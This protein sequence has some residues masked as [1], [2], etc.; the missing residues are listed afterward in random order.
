MKVSI[1]IPCHNEEDAI[2]ACLESCL[3]QTRAHDEI[4][5]VDDGSTD[6]TASILEGYR[7]R[8][9][10]ATI[11][12]A[13]GNKSY[14]QERGLHDVTGDIVVMTDGD[15]ILD[16][17]FVARVV[18]RFAD[19]NIAAVCGYVK[20]I[21]H[22]WLTACREIEYI[23]AQEITKRLQASRHAITVIPGCAAVFRTAIFRRH[24]GFDHD[25]LTEDRDFT[26]KLHEARLQILYA[27]DAI[28]HTQDP[29]TLGAYV[30]QVRRWYGGS[31]QNLFKHRAMLM[32]AGNAAR[33]LSGYVIMLCAALSL[34]IMP[35]FSVRASI[36][37]ALSLC[38]QT[39]PVSLYAY[40]VRGRLDLIKYTPF[41]L[42]TLL[43]RAW[44]FVEQ[45]VYQ[46]ILRKKDLVWHKPPRR[47]VRYPMR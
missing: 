19:E 13:T 36:Y 45:F 7:G 5:V 11:A 20:S 9:K 6:R 17:N 37:L 27:R 24:V 10:I 21:D 12:N 2:Q 41:S 18:P 25:T 33:F 35:I 26:F 31:W 39:L 46:I 14:A 29:A 40:L 23:I 43:I 34:C 47:P 16:R 22:N 28:V 44:I 1:L 3:H 38:A 30:R 42:I 4:V 8:I 32:R 15:T